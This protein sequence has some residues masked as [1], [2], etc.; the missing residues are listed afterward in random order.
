MDVSRIIDERRIDAFNVRL[1]VFSFFIVLLDGYDITAIS[2][3]APELVRAWGITDRSALG[4]VFSA[5]LVGMLFGAPGLGWVGDRYGRRIAIVA[6]CA[7]FGVFTWGTVLAD[8]LGHLMVLRF[9]AGIGIGGLL[10]NAIALNAEFAP[11]RLRATMIILMFTGVTFGGAL[12]ALV[13]VALVPKFGWQALFV[14]GGVLPILAAAAAALWL[15]ESIKYLVV[16]GGARRSAEVAALLAKMGTPA[17]AKAGFTVQGEKVYPDLSVRR[18]FADGLGVITPLL[19][20][21][22]VVNLMVFYFLISWTPTLLTSA[23]VP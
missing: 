22:F 10:P 19:W 13:S 17:D 8:S 18:L 14:V 7:I 15:P 16:K 3:A 1:V 9:L 20:F 5:S 4:P 2:F 12:P 23:N 21:L 11:K 6:S